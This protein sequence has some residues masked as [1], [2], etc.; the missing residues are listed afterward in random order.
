MDNMTYED[1][2]K[3]MANEAFNLARGKAEGLKSKLSEDIKHPNLDKLKITEVDEGTP[4]KALSDDQKANLKESKGA[5]G[6][7]KD[8]ISGVIEKAKSK[9]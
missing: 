1:G 5:W 2:E 8:K 6:T 4:T 3:E 7:A 9:L